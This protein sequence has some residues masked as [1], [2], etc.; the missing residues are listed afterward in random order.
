[1]NKKKD[2]IQNAVKHPGAFTR[3]CKQQ[4]YNGVTEE[5]IQKGCKSDNETIRRRAC[6]AKVFRKIAKKRK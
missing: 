6:L 4:G 5:C 1:M 3:W 2:W